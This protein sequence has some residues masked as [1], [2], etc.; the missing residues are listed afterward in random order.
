MT[1]SSK[2]IG[3][4]TGAIVWSFQLMD[5]GGATG[6]FPEA[7]GVPALTLVIRDTA[8]TAPRLS[9]HREWDWWS[10]EI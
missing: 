4:V 6:A 10:M 2:K 8:A 9:N 1:A 5:S 7:V 3:F